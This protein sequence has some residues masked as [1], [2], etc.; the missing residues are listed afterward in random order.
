MIWLSDVLAGLGIIVTVSGLTFLA[1][2]AT[3]LSH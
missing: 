2:V 3:T 1:W